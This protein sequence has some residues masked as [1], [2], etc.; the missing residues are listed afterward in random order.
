MGKRKTSW[1]LV[2]KDGETESKERRGA[3]WTEKK[4]AEFKKA[5]FFLHPEF[6]MWGL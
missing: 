5:S 6:P 2:E 3:G 4:D 1:V